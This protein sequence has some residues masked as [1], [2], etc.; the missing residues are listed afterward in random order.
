MQHYES[1]QT[2]NRSAFQNC[3]PIF[4]VMFMGIRHEK[5]ANRF[6]KWYKFWSSGPDLIEQNKYYRWATYEWISKPTIPKLTESVNFSWFAIH[7]VL[8]FFFL[9]QFPLPDSVWYNL[10]SNII[11][12]PWTEQLFRSLWRRWIAN[13]IRWLFVYSC[14]LCL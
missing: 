1:D 4:I 13:R 12:K 10:M 7:V 6:Q 8:C 5:Y 9:N 14:S 3:G 11:Y 2:N